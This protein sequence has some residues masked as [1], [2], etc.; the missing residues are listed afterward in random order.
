MLYKNVTGMMF[1][2]SYLCLRKLWFFSHDIGLEIESED[3]KIGKIIDEYSYK[4]E[5]KNI[6]IDSVCIDFLED[7]IVYEIKKSDAEKDMQLK[8]LKYYL[9]ILNK[10]GVKNPI[11]I[12]KIPKIKYQEEVYLTNEDITEIN[13]QLNKINEI[14][15]NPKAP[16][17]KTL[18]IETR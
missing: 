2:Y 8:Q 11:G 7:G 5:K 6:V 18:I 14:I 16:K 13:R 17:G 3:V 9:Y 12:L 15:S 1:A 4:R 10:K